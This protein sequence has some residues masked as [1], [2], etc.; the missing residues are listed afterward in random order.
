MSD[1]RTSGSIK[2]DIESIYC[3]K[4]LCAFFVVIIHSSMWGRDELMNLLIIAVPCFYVISGFFL[5]SGDRRKECA[6]AWKW[7]KKILFL[8]VA[9]AVFYAAFF[10]IFKG[11]R[12]A[13]KTF[14][15]CLFAGTMPSVHLWYL[16]SMWQALLLFCVLRWSRLWASWLIIPL[17][18]VGSFWFCCVVPHCYPSADAWKYWRPLWALS[19]MGGGYCIARYR[20]SMLPPVIPVLIMVAGWLASYFLYP[21]GMF[22]PEGEIGISTAFRCC[23]LMIAVSVV[24]LC[25]RFPHCSFPVVSYIG[26]YHSANIYYYHVAVQC[27]LLSFFSH[28]LGIDIQQFSPPLT[29]VLTLFVSIL[30]VYASRL[31]CY[32]RRKMLRR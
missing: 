13:I 11:N 6:K 25:I 29:F 4:A 28:F 9:L 19:L 5:Y 8:Y 21:L 31:M 32:S 12:Y 10:F 23:Y 16:N 14:C 7:M 18:L 1:A 24:S 22:K 20:T 27:I 17:L 26:K 2:P 3:L 15:V 30:L